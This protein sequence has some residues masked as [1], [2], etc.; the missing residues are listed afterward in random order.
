[1]GQSAGNLARGLAA[2]S[3]ASNV[4]ALLQM[5]G[6]RSPLYSGML[7][8]APKAGPVLSPAQNALLSAIVAN[9]SSLPPPPRRELLPFENYIGR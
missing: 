4:E 2:R 9:Q 5:L 8:A 3:T 1:L 7:A 6:Q